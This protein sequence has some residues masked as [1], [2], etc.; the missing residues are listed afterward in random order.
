MGPE[1]Y[2]YHFIVVLASMGVGPTELA[3]LDG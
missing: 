2:W 1:I 3:R